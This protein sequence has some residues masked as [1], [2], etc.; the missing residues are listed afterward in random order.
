MAGLLLYANVDLHAANATIFC[1]Q[2]MIGSRPALSIFSIDGV[3]GIRG[4]LFCPNIQYLVQESNYTLNYVCIESA[5]PT[6]EDGSSWYAEDCTLDMDDRSCVANYYY[7]GTYCAECP[8]NTA[9]STA[10]YAGHNN[11]TCNYCRQNYY[12]SGSDCVP[13]PESGKT[14]AN[15]TAITACYLASGTRTDDTGTYTITDKCYYN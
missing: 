10:P 9:A 5:N 8:N 7:T 12:K 15:G 2:A 14:D 3:S 11:T 13:C 6:R 1:G 4:F